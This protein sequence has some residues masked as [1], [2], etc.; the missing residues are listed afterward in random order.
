MNNN[1]YYGNKI[2][3]GE[4]V[5]KVKLSEL[6]PF[7][8]QPFKVLLDESMTELVDSIKSSGVL[9]PLV[10]RPHKEIQNKPNMIITDWD[11]LSMKE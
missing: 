10:V 2:A 4:Q 9:S 8:E 5:Q 1:M 7:E 11:S 3:E 6:K